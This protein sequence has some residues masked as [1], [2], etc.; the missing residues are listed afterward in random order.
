[1]PGLSQKFSQISESQTVALNSLMAKM[2]REGRDVVALGAGEPDFDTPQ[3]IKDAA[4][5]AIR[6]GKTKYT[7]A[8][9]IMDL[10]EAISKWLADD[11]GAV[12]KPSEIIVTP[13][14]K[15]AVFQ[16]LLAVCNPGDEVL[17][18][19]PYWV[20][21]PEQ[22]KLAGAVLK[23]LETDQNTG[24]KIT[25]EQLDRAITD[26]TKVLIL[27]SPSNPSGAVYSAEE[28]E[29]LARVIEKRGIYVISDEI[30]DKIVYDGVQFASMTKYP[31]IREQLL[32]VNGVS[33]S[34]AMTGW[35]IGYLAA[36]QEIATGVKKFQGHTTSNP[37]SISQ[38]AAL[39]GMNGPK[40][41]I[42]EMMKAFTERRNYVHT[43]LTNMP[44]V[45]CMLPQGAFYA[46]PDFGAYMG[47]SQ[48]GIEIN[49]SIDLCGYLL[50]KFDV[51]IVPGIAFGMDTHARLSFATSME[52]L[53][54]ALNRI[55]RGLASLK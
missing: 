39:G 15:Y 33:K 1:M 29:E 19:V 41:F 14:A 46:F 23:P 18:P 2:K 55:E 10:K 28:L 12:Y 11:Y 8:D 54:K 40:E 31:G 16:A 49:S 13:G 27:N 20:S 24:L 4:I 43:R 52:I 22:V 32:L 17:L 45:S 53:E 5:T 30:Y 44:G 51:A 50:E 47:T 36:P 26:K 35:R 38:Y 34:F 7:P 3:H 37:T 48:D 25:P 42:N 9:G 21:Y 6:Q